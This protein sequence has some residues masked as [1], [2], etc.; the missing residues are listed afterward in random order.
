MSRTLG[1]VGK[2]HREDFQRFCRLEARGYS[3]KEIIKVLWDLEP[4]DKDF[5]RL[6][7]RLSMWRKNPEYQKIWLEELGLGGRRILTSRGLRTRLRTM[8]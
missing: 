8:P 7:D 4:G 2:K 6:R 1:S 3:S 5:I